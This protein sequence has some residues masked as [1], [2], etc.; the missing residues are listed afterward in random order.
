MP[1]SGPP[2]IDRAVSAALVDGIPDGW[3]RVWF[4]DRP[5]GLTKTVRGGGDSVA[6]YAEELGGRDVVSANAYRVDGRWHLRPCEMPEQK[7]LEFLAGWT[8]LPDAFG[9]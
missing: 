5:Y 3:T 6:V 1:E 7:V 8:P 4:R 2:A 9:G